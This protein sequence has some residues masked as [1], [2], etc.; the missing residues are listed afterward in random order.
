MAHAH[1]VVLR[2]WLGHI[3]K[4]GGVFG[5]GSTRDNS[6]P[7]YFCGGPLVETIIGPVWPHLVK[8]LNENFNYLPYQFSVAPQLPKAL[9]VTLYV[10]VKIKQAYKVLLGEK[11]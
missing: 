4:M 1:I 9:V 7:C 3:K 5:R 10:T 11:R 2:F 8:Q 6:A